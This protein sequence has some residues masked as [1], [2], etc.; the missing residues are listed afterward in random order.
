M[1]NLRLVIARGQFSTARFWLVVLMSR[2]LQCIYCQLIRELA[3][4]HNAVP[5]FHSVSAGSAL[6]LVT[7]TVVHNLQCFDVY[8]GLV[9]S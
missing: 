4:R 8:L 9:E 1:A 2:K 5:L 6:I 7:E 3:S